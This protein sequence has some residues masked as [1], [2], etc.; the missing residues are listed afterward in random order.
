LVILSADPALEALWTH[1]TDCGFL[2]ACPRL[3][4]SLASLRMSREPDETFSGSRSPAVLKALARRLES[5]SSLRALTFVDS[6]VWSGDREGWDPAPVATVRLPQ[7]TSMQAMVA[8]DVPLAFDLP[9]LRSLDATEFRPWMKA[10]ARLQSLRVM[11]VSPDH[12]AF[13]R[14]LMADAAGLG[15]GCCFPQLKVR[16]SRAAAAIA[17]ACAYVVFVLRETGAHDQQHRQRHEPAPALAA[18]PG[19]QL[20]PARG[21]RRLGRRLPGTAARIFAVGAAH[22]AC[23]PADRVRQSRRRSA[24]GLL[25]RV[26]ADGSLF[27][28]LRGV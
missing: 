25:F 26:S 23:L 5:L 6:D 7:L 24:Q 11:L 3:R 22:G 13:T 1:D 15:R 10:C 4:G 14:A 2:D 27:S 9:A 18:R 17:L 20:P 12:A 16:A 19:R 21:G 28:L 8:R